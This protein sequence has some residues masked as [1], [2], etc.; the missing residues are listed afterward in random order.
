M[1]LLIYVMDLISLELRIKLQRR[2]HRCV[3]ICTGETKGCSSAK[4]TVPAPLAR[5]P[6][7][8]VLVGVPS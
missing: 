3:S 5:T 2:L 8:G 4:S 6:H 7:T 1:T